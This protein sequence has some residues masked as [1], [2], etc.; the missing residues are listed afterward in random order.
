[1]KSSMK[2]TL[3]KLG[4]CLSWHLLKISPLIKI[5]TTF[6]GAPT[7]LR[8]QLTRWQQAREALRYEQRNACSA[9]DTRAALGPWREVSRDEQRETTRHPAPRCDSRA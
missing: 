3:A 4:S 5:V 7:G 9:I 6:S 2:L 8:R 1:Q